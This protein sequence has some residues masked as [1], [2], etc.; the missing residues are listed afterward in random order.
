MAAW[1]MLLDYRLNSEKATIGKN[2]SL[3][4]RAR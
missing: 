2:F 3:D 4:K 1:S